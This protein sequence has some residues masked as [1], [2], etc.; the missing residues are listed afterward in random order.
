MKHHLTLTGPA[1]R[2]VLRRLDDAPTEEVSI[3]VEASW[4]HDR[5]EW[6]VARLGEPSWVPYPRGRVL[7]AASNSIE[8]LPA[9][10]RDLLDHRP[11]QR[12]CVALAVGIGQAAGH[13]AGICLNQAGECAPLNRVTIVGT[14]IHVV[15][16]SDYAPLVRE[17]L[18]EQSRNIGDASLPAETVY[19][20]TLG[21]LG[22]QALQGFRALHVAQIGAGRSG[23]LFAE[24]L[25]R[26]AISRL[27]LIDPDKLEAHNLGEMTGVGIQDLGR[28]KVDVLTDNFAKQ[29]LFPSRGL[30]PIA[31]SV[32]GL[33]ALAAIK[34]ANF[35]LCA[36]DNRPALLATACLATLYVKPFGALGT[37]IFH[38][39]GAA[40]TTVAT[41][42]PQWRRM[43]ADIRLVLPGRCLL[44]LGGVGRLDESMVAPFAALVGT[45][46]GTRT[47][48]DWQRERS[49]SL[50][51]LNGVGVHLLLRLLEDFIAERVEESVWLHLEFSESGIPTIEHRVPRVSRRCP[52]CNLAGQGDAGVSQLMKTVAQGH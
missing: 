36:V 33:P 37:G 43:G 18:G 38:A 26:L 34:R 2:E 47:Q 32:F 28:H 29:S 1:F 15:E 25:S 14:G 10:V 42:G 48:E 13:F 3:G 44:C 45:N 50:R 4:H 7:I 27:T 41:S 40:G 24:A 23:S 6:L 46:T 51:S 8:G 52:L 30:D 49:G 19:S 20:R 11:M 12:L 22:P 31:E 17:N 16:L 9:A 5:I 21:A 35:L 39:R